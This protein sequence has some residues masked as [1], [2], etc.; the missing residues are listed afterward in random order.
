MTT[1]QKRGIFTSG[2]IFALLLWM[3]CGD[4]GNSTGT[5]GG[6]PGGTPP[7]N[8]TNPGGGGGGSSS[9]A[10]YVYVGTDANAGGI[11][12][13]KLDTSSGNLA[14]LS[15]SPTSLPQ[16]FTTGASL[17]ASNGFV[18]TVN[19]AGETQGAAVYS[20]K[21]DPA[22]GVL[23]PVG[24]GVVV[25]STNDSDIGRIHLSTDGKTAYLISQFTM[26]AIALGDGNPSKLNSQ[27]LTTGASWGF[28]V[29]KNFAYAG[30]QDG[31][32]KTGFAQ[33][34][35]ERLNINGD[36]SLGSPQTLVTLTDSNI[37][38]DLTTDANGKYVAATTGFNNNSVS[39]WSIDSGSGALT[40]VAGS[41]FSNNDEIGKTLRF[42]PDGT[43]LYLINNPGFEPR[44]EDVM[45]FNVASNGALTLS[46]TLDLGTGEDVLDFKVENDFAYITNQTDGLAGNLIV[47]KR[48][49]GTG[50]LSV[51]GKTA[52]A[53]GSG[54]VDTLHFQ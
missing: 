26:T 31:N 29:T 48:D 46:Q 19:R 27:E 17:V 15:G 37:P 43:H 7:P 36:A 38:Y 12:S 32:P 1:R 50:Q 42:D 35:I 49:S 13:F 53:G 14:E 20:F 18:Y 40:A 23:S 6:N 34:V 5:T 16:G 2:M 9:P 10:T 47:L 25:T 24:S 8:I 4:N 33:P 39:V 28:G 30:V 21:A 22:S 51:V 45:V 54:G 52:M 11:R 44:A 41:P 3:A